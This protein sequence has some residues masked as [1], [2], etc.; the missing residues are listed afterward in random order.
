MRR[1]D[2]TGGGA[3]LTP[4]LLLSPTLLP[5]HRLDDT[6]PVRLLKDVFEDLDVL[7]DLDILDILVL[8]ETL[9]EFLERVLEAC[10]LL[11][12]SQPPCWLQGDLRACRLTVQQV[13]GKTSLPVMW[14]PPEDWGKEDSCW[15]NGV[16]AWLLQR[17][18]TGLQ[19]GS[20]SL[21]Y[22]PLETS[23]YLLCYFCAV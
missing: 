18:L 20:G 4:S 23:C 22:V 13:L 11:P 9:E 7:D 16:S 17:E 15:C 2:T 10:P 3:L 12:W 6:L 21:L 14:D 8:L 5:G 1:G 19:L